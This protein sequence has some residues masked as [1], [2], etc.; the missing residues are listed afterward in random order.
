MGLTIGVVLG[1][2]VISLYLSSKMNEVDA[3][4]LW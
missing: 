2:I 4:D 3:K 1:I